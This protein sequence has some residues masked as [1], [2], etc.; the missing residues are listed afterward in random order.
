M[1]YCRRTALLLCLVLASQS[2]LFAQSRIPN[3]LR[4][5]AQVEQ[6]HVSKTSFLQ[7]I[8]QNHTPKLVPPPS[9]SHVLRPP[10]PPTPSAS[11]QVPTYLLTDE[12]LVEAELDIPIN[13]EQ[14]DPPEPIQIDERTL[15]NQSQT[16]HRASINHY[17]QGAFNNKFQTQETLPPPETD[18]R[19]V[20]PVPY[21]VGAGRHLD[22]RSVRQHAESRSQ[23]SALRSG[24]VH[25]CGD[26]RA[27]YTGR[28]DSSS[29]YSQQWGRE[30]K[31]PA[32]GKWSPPFRLVMPGFRWGSHPTNQKSRYR[33]ERH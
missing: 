10:E 32:W 22:Q 29:K 12:H 23:P 26:R 17:V 20:E 7:P 5:Q 13:A 8:D 25:C 3:P 33:L 15:Q 24:A 28:C 27:G 30:T 18:K 4:P 6:A 21:A 16:P 11:S 19:V 31:A 1:L 2:S 9:Q 14:F